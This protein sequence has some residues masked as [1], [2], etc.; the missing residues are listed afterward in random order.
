MA[1]ANDPPTEETPVAAPAVETAPT[2]LSLTQRLR[3]AGEA[4]ASR[5]TN[6]DLT[7]ARAQLET[8]TAD[9]DNLRA[10]LETAAA[11]LAIVSAERDAARAAVAVH[12]AAVL[13]FEASVV[14]R[15]AEAG[16]PAVELPSATS[17]E[18]P[19]T[20]LREKLATATDPKERGRI[21]QELASLRSW[22]N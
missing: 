6:A 7:A 17:G 5:G 19:E 16:V 15:C 3:A 20:A 10:A 22:N 18:N 2:S 4:L 1:E 14:Q 21:C 12:E 9:R 8:L 11:S 13:D